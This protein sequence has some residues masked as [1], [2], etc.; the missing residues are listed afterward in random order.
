MKQGLLALGVTIACVGTASAQ[1]PELWQDNAEEWA[2]KLFGSRVNLIHDFGEV[3]RGALLS[4]EFVMTNI[5]KVPIEITNIRVPMGAWT[6]T[7]NKWEL[8]RC[9]D[10]RIRV[11]VDA[12]RFVGHKTAAVY[13]TVG[14]NRL[15]TA[16]LTVTATVREDIVCNPGEAAFGTVFRG[17]TPGAT[18]A[19]EYT[20]PLAWQVS[21]AVVPKEAPFEATVKEVDRSPG[22]VRY[23]V[24]ITIKQDAT[25]GAFHERVLLK[26]NDPSAALLPVFVNGQIQVP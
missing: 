15:S 19:V 10:A 18:L 2:E 6:A 13:V 5:Y 25:P 22:K 1:V 9:Q 4:H 24:K 3:P 14:P 23:E 7:T 12:R 16:R 21:E 26:T 11:T 8:K 20:G 17:Q